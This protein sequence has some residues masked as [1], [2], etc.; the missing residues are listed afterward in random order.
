[1]TFMEVFRR[2]MGLKSETFAAS[3]FLEIKVI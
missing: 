1:M 3:S 2:E